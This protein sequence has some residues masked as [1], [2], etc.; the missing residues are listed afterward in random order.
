MCQLI[1]SI[2]LVIKHVQELDIDNTLM[3]LME[4]DCDSILLPHSITQLQSSTSYL[5]AASNEEVS[6]YNWTDSGELIHSCTQSFAQ[7]QIKFFAANPI[8]QEL[9]LLHPNSLQI[10]T[11]YGENK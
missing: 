9:A 4:S 10:T 6:I 11:F 5:A 8:G 3:G 7:E 1:I 2:S